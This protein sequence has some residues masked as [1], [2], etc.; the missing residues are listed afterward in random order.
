MSALHPVLDKQLIDMRDELD[1]I[2][3]G[4]VPVRSSRLFQWLKPNIQREILNLKSTNS[5]VKMIFEAFGF[6]SPF[7]SFTPILQIQT[8]TDHGLTEQLYHKWL[9]EDAVQHGQWINQ[10]EMMA[11]VA[12]YKIYILSFF[13]MVKRF[14]EEFR[15]RDFLFTMVPDNVR[16]LNE[17]SVKNILGKMYESRLNFIFHGTYLPIIIFQGS[18]GHATSVVMLPF[19]T[20]LAEV[21][22]TK[23]SRLGKFTGLGHQYCASTTSV[24]WHIVFINSNGMDQFLGRVIAPLEAC[25]RYKQFLIENQCNDKITHSKSYCWQNIQREF[26][27][28]VHWSI[29]LAFT[30]LENFA[31]H[32]HNYTGVDESISKFC[33]RI[34][35]STENRA[36]MDSFIGCI[37][38][39]FLVINNMLIDALDTLRIKYAKRFKSIEKQNEIFTD[40]WR[41][42]M[43]EIVEL[44]LKENGLGTFSLMIAIFEKTQND[45]NSIL[46]S[47]DGDDD[48]ARNMSMNEMDR[49][50]DKLIMDIWQDED[51]NVFDLMHSLDRISQIPDEKQTPETLGEFKDKFGDFWTEVYSE[52]NLRLLVKYYFFRKNHEYR[53]NL[54]KEHRRLMLAISW[55]SQSSSGDIAI[56]DALQRE[57]AENQE[58][59]RNQLQ[60][61][62]AEM[63]RFISFT[64]GTLGFTFAPISKSKLD[65]V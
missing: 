33:K 7:V 23:W 32:R 56:I 64:N 37:Q 65:S 24:H 27:T 50:S 40:T 17:W 44:L 62:N 12:P 19:V 4:A 11:D 61:Q 58:K 55:L 21:P 57:L 28:C 47:V 29:F 46:T 38:D 30:I 14:R 52:H 10:E 6:E 43:F 53:I 18:R 48:D 26:G 5:Q 15:I 45:L 1:R 22:D 36:I 3:D 31:T 41:P 54:R 59:M 9:I 8:V 49:F 25:K 34:A 63:N 42:H 16:G 51:S 60:S 39:F 35:Q 2:R 13:A 20:Q